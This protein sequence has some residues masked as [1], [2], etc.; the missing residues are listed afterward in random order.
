MHI[1]VLHGPNL[2]MLGTRE[3]HIYG[4]TTL[5]D[6]N[7]AIEDRAQELGA[8]TRVFQSNHEGAIIDV[9]QAEAG[10][11]DGI[12]I[13]PGGL[14]HYSIALRDALANVAVPIVEVHLSN[15]YKREEF[16]HHSVTAPVA[17]GQ[18]SGL[19]WQGYLLALEW[20]AAQSG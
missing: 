15:I 8:T 20:L 9:I 3:P 7:A 14:T 5:G 1:L 4:S 12:V 19:G 13:N 10:A 2:N 16:R 18:I 17:T 11:A 6:I